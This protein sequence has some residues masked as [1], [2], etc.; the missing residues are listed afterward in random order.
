MLGRFGRD[1]GSLLG[2]EIASDSIRLLQLHR[3]RGR[4][5]V[6]A[7]ALEPL[8]GD[9][10][11][12]GWIRDPEP[13]IAALRRA[14][15]RAGSPQHRVAVAIPGSQVIS[16]VRRLSASLSDAQMEAQ[17]LAE[18]DQFIPFPLEDTALD[19]QVLGPCQA[20]PDQ[21]D[22]VVAACRQS[23]LD[24][25]EQ[26][27]EAAGLKARL[28]DI[29]S[30]ALQRVLPVTEPAPALLQLEADRATLHAWIGGPLPVRQELRL[31]PA[32]A[33]SVAPGVEPWL[34]CALQGTSLDVLLLAGAGAARGELAMQLQASLG[35]PTRVLEPLA[36]LDLRTLADAEALDGVG[37]SMALACGLA[38]GGLR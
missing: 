27:L 13:V 33:T 15:H 26:I 28:V 9:A 4:C 38:M 23:H 14:R 19:F 16:K 36:G 29:D 21:V 8:A 2:L 6:A 32:Q 24:P 1:A 11:R 18:A 12:D 34:R 31:D 10:V 17:L 22:V 25:F 7:W 20:Q 30:H 3:R 37:S 35:I 5:G